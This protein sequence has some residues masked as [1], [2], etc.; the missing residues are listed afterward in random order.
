MFPAILLF[1][2]ILL[3]SVRE[4]TFFGQ[5]MHQSLSIEFGLELLASLFTVHHIF[6]EN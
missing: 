6:P 2:L 4:R 1:P 5:C 3:V